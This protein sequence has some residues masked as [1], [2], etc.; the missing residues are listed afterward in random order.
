MTQAKAS[1]DPPEVLV[2]GLIAA[3]VLG[4]RKPPVTYS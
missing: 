4:V 1:L 3:P 2:T